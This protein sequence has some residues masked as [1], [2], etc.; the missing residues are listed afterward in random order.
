MK[1]LD[2]YSEATNFPEGSWDLGE[3]AAHGRGAGDASGSQTWTL[4]RSGP[5]VRALGAKLMR[6]SEKTAGHAEVRRNG[7]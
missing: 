4:R 1:L 7:V 2:E 6:D 3:S 5:R